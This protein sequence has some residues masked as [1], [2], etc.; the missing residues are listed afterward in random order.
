MR[1]TGKAVIA[2]WLAFFGAGLAAATREDMNPA[3]SSSLTMAEARGF[4]EVWRQSDPQHRS[5]ST[6][7]PTGSMVPT[8]DSRCLLLLEKVAASDLLKNDIALYSVEDGGSTCH[9]VL[10]VRADGVFFSGDSNHRSDGWI[11][12]HRILW[13]VA[14]II[15]TRR[16]GAS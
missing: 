16:E 7:K 5:W 13:R 8:L 3:P 2:A 14:S 15:F 1:F 4:G 12:P 6:V 10:E 9:R 11:A